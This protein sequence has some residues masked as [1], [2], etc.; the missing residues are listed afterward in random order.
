MTKTSEINVKHNLITALITMLLSSIIAPLVVNKITS[1]PQDKLEVYYA[2]TDTK[3]FRP[4]AIGGLHLNYEQDNKINRFEMSVRNNGRD[5]EGIKEIE[6][7]IRSMRKNL[8]LPPEIIYDPAMI[9][10]RVIKKSFTGD[11]I[12]MQLKDLPSDSGVVFFL[13]SKDYFEKKDIEIAVIG[14]GRRWRAV[15]KQVLLHAPESSFWKNLFSGTNL[16]AFEAYALEKNSA[17]APEKARKSGVYFGGYDPVALINEIFL[18][19]QNRRIIDKGEA[20]KI[21]KSIAENT[22]GV[23]I[24]GVDILKFDELVLN[25]LIQKKVIN[26]TEASAIIDRSRNAGGILINGY[27]PIYLN[28][29]I[30]N[31]LIKGK[32]ISLQEAQAAL[33]KSRVQ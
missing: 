19:L 27:N 33:D 22:S 10:S 13:N 17:Q 11:N 4:D 23:G 31:A 15:E 32:R 29:E 8:F 14:N 6:I 20:D 21:M 18:I 9:V 26:M 7:D 1:K 5:S 30:L 3:P 24:G 16:L 12:N 2:L 25:I 28:A